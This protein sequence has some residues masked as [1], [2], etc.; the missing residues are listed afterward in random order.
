MSTNLIKLIASELADAL[1]SAGVSEAATYIEVT[2][3]AR[4]VLSGGRNP[5]NTSHPCQAFVSTT[6]REKVGGTLVEKSDRVVCIVGKTLAVQPS[7]TGRITIDG[8]TQSIVDIEGTDALW[9]L[10]CRG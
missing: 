5:I 3:G 2:Q 8:K 7:T 10:L 1:P 9:T 4:T 6:R